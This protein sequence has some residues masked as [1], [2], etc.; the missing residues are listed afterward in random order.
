MRFCTSPSVITSR[1]RSC[2]PA[3][4]VF[5]QGSSCC[6]AFY[7]LQPHYDRT[8][9]H[10][11]YHLLWLQKGVCAGGRDLH[12]LQMQLTYSEP[13]L[14]NIRRTSLFSKQKP[15]HPVYCNILGEPRKTPYNLSLIP[16]TERSQQGF[17]AFSEERL[18]LYV[19]RKPFTILLLPLHCSRSCTICR[20]GFFL[21]ENCSRGLCNTTD[22]LGPTSLNFD[23]Q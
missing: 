21:F 23:A 18:C 17:W 15:K 5:Y 16:P 12:M 1:F 10:R 6:F 3:P 19:P 13:G 7:F 2:L 8:G 20:N 9:S 22:V 11:I 14:N 4:A